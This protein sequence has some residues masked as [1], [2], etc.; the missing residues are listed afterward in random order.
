MGGIS[1]FAEKISNGL[2]K[3]GV[4]QKEDAELYRYGVENGIVMAGNLL[5]A[6]VVGVVTR[7]LGIVAAF[8]FFY[9]TLRSYSGGIHCKSRWLCYLCSV[10]VLFLPV[11]SYHIIMKVFPAAFRISVLVA[12][13]LVIFVLTPV[14]SPKKRLDEEERR[15]FM[16]TSH[17]I[18]GIQLCILIILY[19]I[20]AYHYF[21]AGYTS[22][23]FNS[24]FYGF[25]K[26]QCKALHL[27][28]KW[29]H[30]VR[31]YNILCYTAFPERIL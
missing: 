3:N 8:L 20:E 11:Y 10:F 2:V 29:L 31:N 4:I 18:V 26:N 7:R 19:C 1:S 14:E 25:W 16:R 13:F 9:G 27:I 23:F 6:V 30:F 15:F 21:C 17:C 5:T 22:I 12:A 24:T 28:V